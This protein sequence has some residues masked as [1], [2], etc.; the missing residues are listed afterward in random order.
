M[1]PTIL[2]TSVICTLFYGIPWQGIQKIKI[3][4]SEASFQACLQKELSHKKHPLLCDSKTTCP[5][6][7]DWFTSKI[8][9][10]SMEKVLWQ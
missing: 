3:V 6:A 5:E 8:M 9:T 7:N 2:A 4:W 10:S 1:C